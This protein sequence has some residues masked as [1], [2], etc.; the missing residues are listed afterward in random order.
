MVRGFF[1][2]VI[3]FVFF[4]LLLFFV[5]VCLFVSGNLKWMSFFPNRNSQLKFPDYLFLR[6][7]KTTDMACCVP[8]TLADFINYKLFNFFFSLALRARITVKNDPCV[9]PGNLFLYLQAVLSHV[10]T[11]AGIDQMSIN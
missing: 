2:I 8:E 3:S 4:L 7:W 6:Q 1:V 10:V 5:V 11:H 9:S